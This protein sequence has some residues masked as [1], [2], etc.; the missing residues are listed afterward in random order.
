MTDFS[1][2]I[3]NPKLLIGA[4]AQFGIFAAYMVAVALG[5]APNQAGI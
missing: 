2:L 4:V 1:A 5:F 3:S